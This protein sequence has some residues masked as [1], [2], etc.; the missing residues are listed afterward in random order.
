MTDPTP[1]PTDPL[2]PEGA[3]PDLRVEEGEEDR[4][5]EEHPDDR[6]PTIE[7][8]QE[9]LLAAQEQ[10]KRDEYPPIP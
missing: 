2:E 7:E 4:G 5:D 10:D 9:T 1:F 6:P 3:D 8:Q